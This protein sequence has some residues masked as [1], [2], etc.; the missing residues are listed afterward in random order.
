MI[1][2]Y[3]DNK[4]VISIWNRTND[5]DIAIS[6]TRISTVFF[7][8]ANEFPE[9][10]LVWSHISQKGNI[11]FDVFGDVFH[12]KKIMASFSLENYLPE[13]IG[14]VEESPFI[15]VNKSVQY[16]TWRMSSNIG[17]IYASVLN[18]LTRRNE[19]R[20][21]DYFLSSIAKS[22]MP[23]GLFCYSEP[24]LVLQKINPRQTRANTYSLFRFVSQHYKT[25]WTL[26]LF[27][28]LL[29]YDKKIKFLPFAYS[30]FFKKR[31]VKNNILQDI[32]VSSNKKVDKDIS[33]DVI[34]PTIGRKGYL[35][36]VLGDLS[37]QTILPVKVIIVEQNPAES[38]SSELDYI[39]NDNWPFK[40]EHIFTHQPGACNA[41]NLALRE[42]ESEYVFFADD[43]IRIEN[44]L[45]SGTIAFMNKFSTNVAVLKCQMKGENSEYNIFSQTT[46]FGS[47]CSFVKA[48]A[49]DSVFFDEKLEFGYGEDIEFGMQ[50][51]N[52]GNDVL[53]FPEPEILHLKAP[54]GGFRIANFK[55]WDSEEI[56]P[57]PSPTLMVVKLRYLS[58]SQLKGYKTI[59]FLK[60]HGVN[61]FALSRFKKQWNRSIYWANKLKDNA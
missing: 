35:Y 50:L 32:A 53:F 43:D 41:R 18:C 55:K 23:L 14:Y 54:I 46:I 36:D 10:L 30:I 59:L 37:A 33:V 20:N 58:I 39:K 9:K 49:L 42:S 34:I 44:N 3:H 60:M 26:L 38:S 31:F 5:S 48:E 51:R 12:H 27:L 4:R 56:H 22:L 7:Q 52:K 16:P 6:A 47:G 29:L 15:N 19:D 13:N 8:L 25:R 57:K 61:I 24:S 28:N 1:V 11:N 45:I 17:G 2:V 21:F 40:I